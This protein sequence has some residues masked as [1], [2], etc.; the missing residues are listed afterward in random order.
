MSEQYSTVL[1]SEFEGM[2]ARIAEL[3]AQN[4]KLFGKAGDYCAAHYEA[5]TLLKKLEAWQSEARAFLRA[6]V[7]C[8]CETGYL[9][10]RCAL[11]VEP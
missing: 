4:L 3:E 5:E 2:K 9:C 11:L 8:D 7:N 10:S 6:E 1:T